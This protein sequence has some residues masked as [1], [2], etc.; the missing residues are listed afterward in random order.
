VGFLRA[1]VCLILILLTTGCTARVTGYTSPIA[2]DY[3][4]VEWHALHQPVVQPFVAGPGHQAAIANDGKT[5]P[6]QFQERLAA[7][8]YDART[9]TLDEI[10]VGIRLEGVDE[11]QDTGSWRTGARIQLIDDSGTRTL[12]DIALDDLPRD[13]D[14]LTIEQPPSLSSGQVVNLRIVPGE[15]HDADRLQY[16]VTPDRAPYGAWMA[17]NAAG[18]NAGGALLLRTVYERD[19]ALRPMLTDTL[20]QL[21]DAAADDLAF[22][23]VWAIALT[24][25][26]AGA[27]WL[28]RL[29]P[30]REV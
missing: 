19:V 7:L 8:P 11:A 28:W 17:T 23:A 24:G 26:L 6:E 12:L 10:N 29:R 27:G 4:D 30:V 3:A 20:H 13:G 2:H 15:G 16:G 14:W 9:G 21:R 18:S 1:I 22:S 5:T 25:L